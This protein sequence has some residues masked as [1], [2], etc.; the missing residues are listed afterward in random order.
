[1]FTGN[2]KKF[3]TFYRFV[4]DYD[5][6]DDRE[7]I[8][9]LVEIK[10]PQKGMKYPVCLDGER[11]CPPEDCGGPWSYPEFLET[12][13]GKNTKERREL[14]EWLGYEF[15]PEAFDIEEVNQL[16]RGS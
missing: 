1:M 4:Y 5:F 11:A 8:V 14:L 3:S 7:H 2:I 16:L 6:G 13:R 10:E 9:E 12:L 15:D